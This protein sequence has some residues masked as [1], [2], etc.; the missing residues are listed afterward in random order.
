MLEIRDMEQQIESL[1]TSSSPF[2]LTVSNNQGS[3]SQR[4][5]KSE[6]QAAFDSSLLLFERC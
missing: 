2:E 1:F 3:R 5:L 6:K 4:P